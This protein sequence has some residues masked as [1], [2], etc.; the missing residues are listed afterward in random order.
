MREKRFCKKGKQAKLY[1]VCPTLKMLLDSQN[2]IKDIAGKAQ[3]DYSNF[4]K[5]CKLGKDIRLSTYFKCVSAFD[6]DLILLAIPM[7]LVESLITPR[8][9]RGERFYT[10]EEKD[11]IKV[12][13]MMYLQNSE[14]LFL[15]FEYF[16][17]R[18]TAEGED[19]K[20]MIL[21]I[22][23]LIQATLKTDES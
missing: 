8:K 11:L 9:K 15:N 18:L 17:R 5:T 3:M 14:T 20:K 7:G 4:V 10:I 13:R 6:R 2:N 22:S 1:I 23:D 12:F 21:S 16:L 19:M